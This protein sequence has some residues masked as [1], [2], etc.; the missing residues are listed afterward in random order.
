MPFQVEYTNS[1]QGIETVFAANVVGHFTLI[2]LL[3]P[4]LEKTA[5]Q[6]GD[7]RVALASSSPHAGCQ[8]L[9]FDLLIS[10]EPVKTPREID[11]CWRYCRSKLGVILITREFARRLD[12]KGVDK[13][14]VNTYFPGNI[15]TD[16]MTPW[17]EMFGP[18]GAMLKGAFQFIG[19]SLKDASATAIYLA[20]SPEVVQKNEKGLYFIPIGTEDTKNTTPIAR[21][22]DLA[23]NLWAWCDDKVTKTLGKGWMNDGEGAASSAAGQAAI[24]PKVFDYVPKA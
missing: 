22:D 2:N 20:T 23:R 6:Y 10:P 8:E 14:F 24:E 3:L 4:L 1:P 21:D 16:A 7:A 5:E 19:Q 13:V 17:K 11:S 9:N 15:P 18:F 12:K